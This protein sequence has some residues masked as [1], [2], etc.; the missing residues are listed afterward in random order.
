MGRAKNNMNWV[1][2]SWLL[3]GGWGRKNEFIELLEIFH[4]YKSKEYRVRN[5]TLQPLT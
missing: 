5:V 4:S 2:F 1:Y 3:G